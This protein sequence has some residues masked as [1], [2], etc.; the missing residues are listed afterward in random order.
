MSRNYGTTS[1]Y[2]ACVFRKDYS[3]IANGKCLGCLFCY[4]D[5]ESQPPEKRR[6]ASMLELEGKISPSL[7]EVPVTL[8][9]YCEPFYNKTSTKHSIYAMKHILENGGQVIL[10]S[11]QA[12]LPGEIWELIKDKR[13]SSNI[14]YQA[15]FM[16]ASTNTG[17]VVREM[18]APNFSSASD[19]ICT[20]EKASEFIDV[21]MYFD[22]YIVGINNKDLEQ[23]IS[24][25]KPSKAILRQLFATS[26]FKDWISFT[27]S[28]RF[29]AMLNIPIVNHWT[30]SNDIL[31]DSFA[32]VVEVATKNNTSLSVCGNHF[33]NSLV[34]ED[35]CCQFSNANAF[36]SGLRVNYESTME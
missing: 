23:L 7:Y 3:Y 19:L 1:S 21:A 18:L 34:A 16:A 13:Y 35:N 11:S 12:V 6:L 4:K 25:F 22:P 5:I 17:N 10:R 15:R 14:Q 8:S 32:E 2:S 36:Y 29:G 20:M 31:L 9:R 27:V 26:K 33:L 30:Y 24:E 28:R